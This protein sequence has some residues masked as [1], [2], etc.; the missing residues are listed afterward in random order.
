[1]TA[2]PQALNPFRKQDGEQRISV[3]LV[4]DCDGQEFRA[5]DEYRKGIWNSVGS[6]LNIEKHELNAEE[7][8]RLWL[9]R[10]Y[11]SLIEK[12]LNNYFLLNNGN[13]SKTNSKTNTGFPEAFFEK[14][15]LNF[16]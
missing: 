3:S 6:A 12:N 10:D 9:R 2:L 11:F 13:A 16:S 8:K 15:G 1:M 7:L 5:R 4:I 14:F